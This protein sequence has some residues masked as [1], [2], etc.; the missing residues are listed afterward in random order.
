MQGQVATHT[1]TRTGYDDK[2][3][4]ATSREQATRLSRMLWAGVPLSASAPGKVK[5]RVQLIGAK[6]GK[7]KRNA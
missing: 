6:K 1:V 4:L 7:G 3:V 5:V 2:T